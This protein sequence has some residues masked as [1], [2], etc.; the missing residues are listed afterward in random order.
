MLH[1]RPKFS[2]YSSRHWLLLYV[3]LC[4]AKITWHLQ[5]FQ[6]SIYQMQRFSYYILGQSFF[7]F[8]S[9]HWF[10]IYVHLCWAKIFCHL[11]INCKGS[12]CKSKLHISNSASAWLPICWTFSIIFHFSQCCYQGQ[13]TTN[14]KGILMLAV[15]ILMSAIS[16]HGI[17]CYLSHETICYLPH[18][19]YRDSQVSCQSFEV[20]G[21]VILLS[22]V[23]FLLSI[24]SNVRVL[25][26]GRCCYIFTTRVLI[27]LD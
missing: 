3:H 27:M 24:S 10:L 11:L 17:M 19:I 22:T 1:P 4:W 15:G 9:K 2:V 26:L 16:C 8:S 7:I 20:F 12:K 5:E 21:S 13:L 23:G 14:D 6:L 18:I 25:M